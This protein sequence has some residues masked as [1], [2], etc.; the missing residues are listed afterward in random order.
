M[1]TSSFLSLHY[2]PDLQVLVVRWLLE[3][4]ATQA[5][6]EYAQL[7][8]EAQALNVHRW[9]VDLRRRPLADPELAL[10]VVG[11]WMPEAARAMAP[12]RLRLAYLIPPSLE[13]AVNH[14][15]AMQPS[16]RLAYSPERPYDLGSFQNEGAAMQWLL[17]A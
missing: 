17:N 8:Y 15:P 9:L 1:Y 2:R 4:D 6:H 13:Q 10:W 5:R 14:D 3:P 7:L 16:V 12:A 11:T